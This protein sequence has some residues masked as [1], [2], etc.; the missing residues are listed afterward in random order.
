MAI[1][2]QVVLGA[3]R[4][5]VNGSRA[6]MPPFGSDGRVSRGEPKPQELGH[7]IRRLCRRDR[8]IPLI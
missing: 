4:P 2:R 7:V 6:R 8:P 3:Q 5:A 1:H